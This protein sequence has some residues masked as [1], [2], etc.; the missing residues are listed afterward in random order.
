M[1]I[2]KNLCFSLVVP[3]FLMA[4]VAFAAPDKY[5][6]K[7]SFTDGN[8]ARHTWSVNA[9]HILM[10]DEKPFVPVGGR[11]QVKSWAKDATAEDF[12]SDVDALATL[13]RTGVRDIYVQPAKGGLTGV[14]VAAIQKLLDHLES[15]GFTYGISINDGPSED[16]TAYDVRPGRY[17]HLLPEGAGSV[18]FMVE[19]ALSALYIVISETGGEIYSTGDATMVS[20]GARIAPRSI[21]GSNVAMLY[22][23]RVY[24]ANG[25]LGLPN[26]WD[27]FDGY[28]DNLLGLLRQVKLGKGFRFFVD[29]LPA[30][31]TLS[32]ESQS[33]VPTGEG[34]Y[35]EWAGWLAKR[36]KSVD[37]LESA[38]AMNDR[39]IANFRDGARLLPL[40]GGK[41]G[42]EFLYDPVGD[43]R[44]RVATLNSAFWRD[45]NQFK[46]ES[47]R[48]Y[49]NELSDI[50]KKTVANVPIVYRSSGYSELFSGIPNIRGFD[51][52]GMSAYGR[53]ND[54]VSLH[55]GYIYAQAA[56]ATKNLWLPV[57]ATAD[58]DPE[59][60][61]APGYGSRVSLQADLD[62]LRE[63]GARGFY[64][65]GVR[66]IDP[67]L[68]ALDLS[69]SDEQL[70]W[71]ADYSRM[72]AASGVSGAVA[73]EAFFYPRGLQYAS[74]KQL[75]DG[76]WWLPSVRPHVAYD[77]GVVGRGYSI[78]DADG[79]IIWYLWNPA[80]KRQ[81]HIP[82]PK[83]AKAPG[84]PPISWSAAAN[85]V[86]RKDTIT[87][88]IGPDPVRLV[89]YP[90]P[91]IPA[92]LESFSDNAA[93]AKTLI[94]GLRKRNAMEAGRFELTL[95]G[96][97]KRL[98]VDNPMLSVAEVLQVVH[99]VKALLQP[100]AWLEAESP[101]THSFDMVRDQLG[102]S[103][104]RALVVDRRPAGNGASPVA[105]YK[106]NVRSD[107]PYNV[108]VAAS[109]G[110]I[111]SF[112][113]DEQT[114]L[115]EPESVRP[116]GAPYGDGA[117]VWMKLG[118][119]TIPKG[120][121][122]LEMRANGP[123]IVDVILLTQQDFVP[124]GVT[125]PPVVP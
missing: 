14:P 59:E 37:A 61:T 60:K 58:A 98:N 75:P 91:V 94:A 71:L 77:F 103:G 63:I 16:L 65:D 15:E 76:A 110:A 107:G 28:R 55:A 118:V 45:L 67:K 66:L 83:A 86:S 12:Q 38:W 87:L 117:L 47:V 43:R 35:T 31:L 111:L 62:R 4:G 97:S 40:W 2:V 21:P 73:P 105:V 113:L 120:S 99:D 64:V 121:H 90:S 34:F 116:T 78:A 106:V 115:D 5:E 54:L 68:K 104:G 20:E 41:V 29:P 79:G 124:N 72:L 9:A 30:N 23:R 101:A 74:V 27:G 49:M 11:F 39:D 24:F 69:Q 51:G 13:K 25:S 36:Y 100:Y 17:T 10:W 114:L 89:N 50:L 88:T 119:A 109:P 57:I 32:I 112:R 123:A 70:S 52:I 56:E 125:P 3:L 26:L 22:P 44:Y 42:A 19:N 53:G 18:R 84:M 8:G 81:I 80:G 108:W 96:A 85:G 122:T 33:L 102:A 46:A 93:V 92:P 1:Q 7:G 95:D 6:T 82:V 48:S